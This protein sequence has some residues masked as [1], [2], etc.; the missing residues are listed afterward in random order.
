[1]TLRVRDLMTP[2]PT[3][4]PAHTSLLDVQELLVV[5]HIGG[6]PVAEPGGAVVGLISASDVLGAVAQALDEDQDEGESED[7]LERLTSITAGEIAS[8]E[9]TWVSPDASATEVARLMRAEGVARVLVGTRDRLE[10]ILT[11]YDLL[12]A[13]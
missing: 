9:V 11:A 13:L 6:V 3:T 10:G 12:R 8:P 1:M 2:N 7:V 4:V 5:A